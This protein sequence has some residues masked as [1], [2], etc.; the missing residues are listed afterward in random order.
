MNFP[1]FTGKIKPK[2]KPVD[3]P[4]SRLKGLDDPTGYLADAG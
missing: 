4:F 1:F 2:K 3:L